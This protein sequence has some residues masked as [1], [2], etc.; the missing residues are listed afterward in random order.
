VANSWRKI[1]IE[2]KPSAIDSTGVG[3]FATSDIRVGQ[4]V[5]DGI[6]ASDFT[7]LIP[8]AGFKQLPKELQRKIMAFCVGT[9]DG[10]VPPPSLDFNKLSI[11]WYL[12][13]SCAGNLGF[14]S[15]GDF[16]AIQP[17]TQGTEL[18]YDYA[19]VESNPR[20]RMA[21]SCSSSGCRRVVTGNDWKDP[22]FQRANLSHMHPRL[23]R[24]A[25]TEPERHT[26]RKLVVVGER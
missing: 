17:I 26:N 5:A 4:R 9:P 22:D 6:R 12:N 18:S 11:E 13:H 8:W 7:H 3:V 1:L 20:F 10:F 19:L 16:I 24:L 25:A 14:D 21:C 15:R 2:L 23:R